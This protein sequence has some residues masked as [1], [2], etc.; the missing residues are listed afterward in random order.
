MRG[1]CREVA[2]SKMGWLCEEGGRPGDACLPLHFQPNL[3]AWKNCAP[4]QASTWLPVWGCMCV[5]TRAI[6][7]QPCNY[8]G[9]LAFWSVGCGESCTAAP[10]P[11]QAGP[12]PH[13]FMCPCCHAWLKVQW[14]VTL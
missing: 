9:V 12:N 2:Q 1:C 5:H 11:G 10:S 14:P 3:P 4:D 7:F 13:T 6:T 8:K